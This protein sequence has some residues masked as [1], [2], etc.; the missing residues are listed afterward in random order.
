MGDSR[1]I[2]VSGQIRGKVGTK[3]SYLVTLESEWVST[4]L[5][6]YKRRPEV[7]LCVIPFVDHNL[8]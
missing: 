3:G 6:V 1:V 5:P 2:S 7:R 4:G 8:K